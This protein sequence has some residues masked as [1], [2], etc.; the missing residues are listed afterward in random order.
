MADGSTNPEGPLPPP[1]TEAG[2]KGAEPP[3]RPPEEQTGA[4]AGGE[5]KPPEPKKPSGEEEMFADVKIPTDEAALKELA[6]EN[7]RVFL[8]EEKDLSKKAQMVNREI[9]RLKRLTMWIEQI[10]TNLRLFG[11]QGLRNSYEQIM[12]AVR[13]G[14][15]EPVSER[16]LVEGLANKNRDF[17]GEATPEQQEE[18]EMLQKID[19]KPDGIEKTNELKAI[20]S[21][22]VPDTP[23]SI[24]RLL[25]KMIAKDEEA[26]EMFIDKIISS[27]TYDEPTADYKLS[28]YAEINLQDLLTE[29][30]NLRDTKEQPEEVR[31]AIGKRYKRYVLQRETAL[32]LHEMNRATTTQSGNIEGFFNIARTVTPEYLQTAT[33]VDGV[34]AVR[35]L[36]E[37]AFGRVYADADRLRPEKFEGEILQWTENAFR[38]LASQGIIKSTFKGVDGQARNLEEWEIKRAFAL[39]RN[40][41][42]SFYRIAELVSWGNVPKPAEEWLKS[43]PGETIVRGLA[44]VKQLI[45]RFRVEQTGGGPEFIT[46]LYD[47]IGKDYKGLGKVGQLDAREEL[48]PIDFQKTGGFDK[49]WR[50]IGA[51]LGSREIMQ[52]DISSLSQKLSDRSRKWLKNFIKEV[53]NGND[54]EANFGELLVNLAQFANDSNAP[55][56]KVDGLVLSKELTPTDDDKAKEQ[57]EELLLPLLGFTLKTTVKPEDFKKI[58]PENRLAVAGRDRNGNLQYE[59]YDYDPNKDQIN[60]S[61]GVL[62][63]SGAISDNLKAVLWRKTARVLPLRMAYFLSEEGVKGRD[64]YGDVKGTTE[65]GRLFREDF[66]KKLIKLQFIRLQEQKKF[67]EQNK[68]HQALNL[69][70]YFAQAELTDVERAFVKELQALGENKA[71]ELVKTKFPHISFLDDV[72][73]QKARYENLGAEVFPR[74]MGSDFEGYMKSGMAILELVK[75]LGKPFEVIKKHISEAR[76]ALSGPEGG[77]T[78]QDMAFTLCLSYFRM[79]RQWGWTK[80]FFIKS[81][82]EFLAKP[83]SELQKIFGP[84]AESMDARRLSLKIRGLAGTGDIRFKTLPGKKESQMDELLREASARPFNVFT[85]ELINTLLVWFFYSFVSFQ[86]KSVSNKT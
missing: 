43:M 27:K 28:W 32:R 44:G 16:I 47:L 78:A 7:I 64:H 34:E 42:S 5:Q 79:A 53:N 71:M 6:T 62:I 19:A 84:N 23:V 31:K 54:K 50:P 38:D 22:L 3:K 9:E 55:L 12:E 30:R 48:L 69:E 73:F 24:S 41:H 2:G 49:G 52:V 72:P 80:F 82:S 29:I 85:S 77:K 1:P 63:S 56:V 14:K 17:R 37:Y 86:A 60:F 59:H 51:Y 33:E 46:V 74:R 68:K 18:K 57:L 10:R 76:D 40:I 36:L 65:E 26:S 13:Q 11:Q 4:A 15:L 83:T 58:K 81:I 75:N 20:I 39:A 61:L 45:K 70:D 8:E 21:Q 66:E 35:Q 25:F 67:F